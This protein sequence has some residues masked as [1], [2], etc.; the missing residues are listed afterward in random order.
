MPRTSRMIIADEK[1]VYH[2]MSRTALD[3]LPLK[4]VEKDFM[5]D[6]IKIYVKSCQAFPNLC[7]RSRSALRGT[8]T[9]AI[10]AEVIFGE[11]VSKASLSIKAK[12]WS[13]ALRISILTRC[14]PAWLIVRKTIA[15]IRLDIIFRPKTKIS[16]C[17]PILDSTNLMSKAQKSGSEDIAGLY[18]KPGR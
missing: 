11:T 1:A 4:D 16:F 7:G 8:I 5:L 18:M 14:G 12:P 9:G 15:G 17:P 13:T 3:G 2:V 6:L 10:T